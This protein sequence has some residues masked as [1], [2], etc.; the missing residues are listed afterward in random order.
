VAYKALYR[1]WRPTNFKEVIGQDHISLTLKNAIEHGRVAHAYLFSGP[2]GTGKTSSAKVLAK[3]LN[4]ENG[5]TP[6]PCNKCEHCLRINSGSSMDVLEIDAAS[7]RG[8]DEIRDLREKV[9][10]AATEGRYKVYIIDEVHM[11]T[12]EAFNALL[13]TLEEPPEQVVFVLATTEP[14]KIPATILSRVQRFDFKR[15]SVPNIVSRLK[16]VVEDFAQEVDEDAL[17]LIARKAEGGMRDALSLLDQCYSTGQRLDVDRV[18][19]VLGALSEDDIYS[20][21][22]KIIDG[23]TFAVINSLNGFLLEGKECVQ[24]VREVVEHLRN[25]LI[26]KATNDGSNLIFVSK[27]AWNK[28]L[29]QSQKVDLERLSKFITLFIKSEGEIK[30]STQ[31]RITLEVALIKACSSDSVINPPLSNNE[32]AKMTPL[33]Q[34]SPQQQVS[35]K[36]RVEDKKVEVKEQVCNNEEQEYKKEQR[37]S[38]SAV[39]ANWQKILELVKKSSI[40]TYAFLIEGLPIDLNKDVL[41]IGFKEKNTFHRDKINQSENKKIVEQSLFTVLG[42]PIGVKCTSSSE[43]STSSETGGDLIDQTYQVFP[44]ELVEIKE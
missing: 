6:E 44:E 27:E 43:F 25:L 34:A 9:K 24:I 7:N 26:L 12:T 17:L 42:Y 16:T 20:F 3:A 35:K 4:C 33:V 28:L 39:K 37:I 2:R 18:V 31:P 13:K 21:C 1:E 8:I 14:H 38:L 10:F 30:N 40:G 22:E 36:I 41:S 19:Q 5:P 23:D 15:I 29:S 11:L 32:S